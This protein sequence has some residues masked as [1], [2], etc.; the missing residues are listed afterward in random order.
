[1]SK[2]RLA[3]NDFGLW[4]LDLGLFVLVAAEGVEPTSLDYRSRALPL[5]YTAEDKF[6]VASLVDPTGLEPAPY[7]LKV[8]YS[9]SRVPGQQ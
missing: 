5:S 6:P 1:M 9:A 2:V 8:R 4:T 3:E 7:G